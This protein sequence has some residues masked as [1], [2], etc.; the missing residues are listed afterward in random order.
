R[1]EAPRRKPTPKQQSINFNDY[2]PILIFWRDRRGRVHF[3]S[4]PGYPGYKLACIL[5]CGGWLPFRRH[6]EACE[7]VSNSSGSWGKPL[8]NATSCSVQNIVVSTDVLIDTSAP[9]V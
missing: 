4:L 7:Y 1:R 8:L 9:I 5:P 2:R 6:H 3:D